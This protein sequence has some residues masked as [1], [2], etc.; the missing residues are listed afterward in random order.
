MGIDHGERITHISFKVQRGTYDVVADG[1]VIKTLAKNESFEIK[2]GDRLSLI[3]PD[4]VY[5]AQQVFFKGKD[6]VN[7]FRVTKN[8]GPSTDYDDHLQVN[9]PGGKMQLINV[10]DIDNYVAA[11]VEAESGYDQPPEFYKL[12]AILCRTYVLKN[13][14]KHMGEGFAVC[15]KVHCQVYHKKCSREEIIK[16][17]FATTSM[18]V[19]D[20]DLQLINTIYHSNCG[21]QTC[22]SEDV[23]SQEISYLRCVNDTF[24]TK[25]SNANWEKVVPKKHLHSYFSGHG[26]M[27]NVYR[28]NQNPYRQPDKK[29]NSVPLTKIRN[30]FGLKSTYFTIAEKGDSVIFYGKGYGHGVGL[31]QQGGICM[32]RQGYSYVDI[33]NHYYQGIHII[34]RN[35]LGFFKE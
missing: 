19:V 2:A 30:D 34:N 32:A 20:K 9:S 10:L 27:E 4:S 31:C 24:C 5:M 8:R 15:D 3:T 16:A 23:W 18:V 33:L 35:A 17:T 26:P 13:S 25:S 1:V 11:V 6:Y 21:G 14:D 7:Y 12:Q 29:I 22:N 28:F